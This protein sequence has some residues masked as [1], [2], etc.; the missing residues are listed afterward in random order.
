MF[1]SKCK[2]CSMMWWSGFFAL[3]AVA[4]IVRL[5][6]RPVIQINGWTAPMALSIGIVLVAGVLSFV[7]CEKGCGAC[8]C[9]NK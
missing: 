4:H 2:C 5:V 8:G 1:C 6:V 9:G 3:A 7:F